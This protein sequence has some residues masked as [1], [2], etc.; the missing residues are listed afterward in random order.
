MKSERHTAISVVMISLLFLISGCKAGFIGLT[1]PDAPTK[2]EEEAAGQLAAND[3]KKP[4]QAA[5]GNPAPSPTTVDNTLAC[6]APPAIQTPDITPIVSCEPCMDL[7]PSDAHTVIAIDF[8]NTSNALLWQRIVADNGTLLGRMANSMPERACIAIRY[9]AASRTPVPDPA[10]SAAPPADMDRISQIIFGPSTP[11]T[12]SLT[13]NQLFLLNPVTDPEVEESVMV[14]DYG[15]QSVP[16]FLNNLISLLRSSIRQGDPVVDGLQSLQQGSR[17]S[18][19]STLPS[20]QNVYAYQATNSSALILGTSRYLLRATKPDALAC[21][22]HPMAEVMQQFAPSHFKIASQ[23]SPERFQQIAD[24]LFVPG[25]QSGQ[26]RHLGAALNL[27]TNRTML[28]LKAFAGDR[29]VD[30]AFELLVALNLEQIEVTRVLG[31]LVG[32]QNTLPPPVC[33]GLPSGAATPSPAT[34]PTPA[35]GS[36][37][38]VELP[39]TIPLWCVLNPTGI[40]EYYTGGTIQ[41]LDSVGYQI[42]SLNNNGTTYEWSIRHPGS[43]FIQASQTFQSSP[44]TMQITTPG[45]SVTFGEGSVNP[46]RFGPNGEQYTFGDVSVDLVV[47]DAAG[48]SIETSST[49]IN[50]EYLG[51]NAGQQLLTSMGVTD[52][53]T[54][55]TAQRLGLCFDPT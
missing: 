34:P 43:L 21:A 32:S 2:A 6:L 42:D 29:L 54:N 44:I 15:S 4:Q 7:L 27:G 3:E 8:R 13:N 14:L 52:P 19:I 41:S 26:Y 37:R 11:S 24:L 9:R 28:N 23:I 31:T 10:C 45:P 17:F 40:P 46:W 35:K 12:G 39:G 18:H 55:R 22:S 36:L 38:I 53:L 20:G 16:V 48:N 30:P 25:F 51:N 49:T 5:E 33:P 1:D 47:R 50:I